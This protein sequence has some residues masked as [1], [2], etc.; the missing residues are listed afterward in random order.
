ML[1]KN[2]AKPLFFKLD[3]ETAHEIVIHSMSTA[4]KIPGMNQITQSILGVK[5]FP[6]L[7]VKV[8][9]LN[10]ANPVGLGAGLDKNAIAV[11][12]FSSIGFGFV[13]VGTVTP[14]PQPG[15]DKPRSFRLPSDEAL[16]NRMGFNNF[17]AD[18]MVK[19]LKQV[20]HRAIP[21]CVNIGKNK[22]TP[23]E[24]AEEDYQTCIQKLYA[25][26]DF[27]TVNISSPNTPDLRKL[28]HGDEL[29]RLLETVV[30]EMDVQA[31]KTGTKKPVFVKIAPDLSS[32]ELK[33]TIELLRSYPIDGVIATN[34]T[35]SRKGLTH[36]NA[37]QMG[38]LSGKPLARMS[39]E[40]IRQIYRLTEGKFPIIGVG[41][42]FTAQ[43]AYE[44]IRAGA[45]LVEI[46]TSLI[47]EGPGVVNRI[48]RGLLELIERDGFSHIS[49]AVGLDT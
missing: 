8:A 38:G 6:Q 28:Q 16:I 49:E 33:Y 23:N 24:R 40:M 42:I 14:K 46:Y 20:G 25:Y 34:T 47:Y 29:S 17:G 21:V 1:Y 12:F 45:S 15:N 26:G 27:F 18:A 37:D 2:I 35:L 19:Q 31:E 9:G 3:P 41:G 13:E 22:L 5:S 10:F 4:G 44:K 48:N 43:D 39:T 32:D 11:K 7:A 36:S 30:K